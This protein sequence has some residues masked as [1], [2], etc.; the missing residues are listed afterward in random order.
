MRGTGTT[1][2]VIGPCEDCQMLQVSRRRARFS[3]GR[4]TIEGQHVQR[5]RVAEVRRCR[6]R[7]AV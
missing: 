3:G 4:L 1:C 5:V 7:D 6:R 2:I